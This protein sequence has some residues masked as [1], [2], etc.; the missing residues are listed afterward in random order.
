MRNRR[1][2]ILYAIA[3]SLVLAMTAISLFNL[4]K[5]ESIT[6]SRNAETRFSSLYTRDSALAI[7]RNNI[8]QLLISRKYTAIGVGNIISDNDLITIENN[9]NN[10]IVPKYLKNTTISVTPTGPRLEVQTYCQELP[11]GNG[12]FDCVVDNFT[13]NFLVTITVDNNSDTYTFNYSGL[14]F[15]VS[16]SKD[17]I[18]LDLRATKFTLL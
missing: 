6:T 9:L 2:S 1:G 13:L 8:Q 3:V 11:N 15:I 10:V 16:E 17:S 5:S 4:Y 14:K 18:S 7:A 12:G